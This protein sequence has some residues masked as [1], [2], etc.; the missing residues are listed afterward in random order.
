M[1]L[2]HHSIRHSFDMKP[3]QKRTPKGLGTHCLVPVLMRLDLCW[4]VVI[5]VVCCAEE[6]GGGAIKAEC[7]AWCS[8]MYALV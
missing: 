8:R 3:P 5:C 6:G 7:A 4:F 1:S 2:P